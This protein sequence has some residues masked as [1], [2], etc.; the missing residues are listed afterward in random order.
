MWFFP[1]RK[2]FLDL[3]TRCPKPGSLLVRVQLEAW[4]NL[5]GLPCRLLILNINHRPSESHSP[6][7]R[8]TL[9]P[10]H[11]LKP[12]SSPSISSY[13]FNLI[14]RRFS[15]LCSHC[16]ESPSTSFPSALVVSLNSSRDQKQQ[17][18]D[19]TATVRW[20]E[21]LGRF[22]SLTQDNVKMHHIWRL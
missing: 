20:L 7:G 3:C 1:P 13:Y 15:D 11:F 21:I 17:S 12:D 10:T 9:A 5:T 6:Q 14:I 2:G 22:T 19:H 8:Q 4:T 18:T 16:L